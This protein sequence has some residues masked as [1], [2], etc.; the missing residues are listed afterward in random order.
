MSRYFCLKL[1]RAMVYQA[2]QIIYR[3][4]VQTAVTMENQL[5]L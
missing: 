1:L 3:R 5:S 4:K 2:T